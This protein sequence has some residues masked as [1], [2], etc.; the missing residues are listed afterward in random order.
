[1]LNLKSFSLYVLLV[2]GSSLLCAASS[3]AESSG[4]SR[5]QVAVTFPDGRTIVSEVPEEAFSE[6]EPSQAIAVYS[7]KPA[8]SSP[9]VPS[10]LL[11]KIASGKGYEVEDVVIL[12]LDPFRVPRFPDFFTDQSANS[13]ANRDALAVADQ[14]IEQLRVLRQPGY[15]SFEEKWRPFGVEVL[16]TFWL[17]N[18]VRA[19][20]PLQVIPEVAAQADVLHVESNRTSTPPPDT[21]PNN[22]VLAA[23]TY[24]RTTSLSGL[25]TGGL[26]GLLDTGVRSSHSLLSNPSPLRFVRDCVN[27]TS[28]NCTTGVNLN[29]DDDCWNHGTASAAIIAGNSNLGN[30]YKGVDDVI[31]DSFKVYPAN[32]MGLDTSA[33]LRGFQAAVAA[34]DQVI[35]AEMQATTS[36]DG[37]IALAADAAY[38][39]GAIVIAANG[40]YGPIFNSTASPAIAHKVLGIGAFNLE[41]LAQFS[42]QSRGPAP[43]LRIKPDIQTPTDSET[44]STA[45]STSVQIFTGTS[46]ATPYAAGMAIGLRNWIAKGGTFFLPGAG[47]AWMI[48]LGQNSPPFNNISGAGPIRFVPNGLFF[49]GKTSLPGL[50]QTDLPLDGFG[51]DPQ[52]P[53][54]LNAAIWWPEA[55]NVNHNNIDLSIVDPGGTPRASSTVL[56]SVFQRCKVAGPLAPGTWKLRIKNNGTR[57]QDV[58]FGAFRTSSQ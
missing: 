11:E 33:V 31:L 16:E 54:N 34:L 41:T 23:R 43:D 51:F 40:N 24:L 38:D 29:P 42:G 8:P 20:I 36:E 1:M 49:Q 57:P 14:R 13:P 7:G 4:P 17:I 25:A 15:S 21:N 9:K 44:A 32:C 58:F 6:L 50:G 28:N 27:G 26:V 30:A 39:A 55:Q 10:D 18:A 2:A 56:N 35:V 12:L 37:A 53:Y 52:F 47:Y 48:L 5:G 22:D 45:S 19:R 3:A 46:G